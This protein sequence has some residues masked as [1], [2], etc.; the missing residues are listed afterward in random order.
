VNSYSV[1]FSVL[2]HLRNDDEVICMGIVYYRW[3]TMIA[4][5]VGVSFINKPSM[6][7]SSY[8]DIENWMKKIIAPD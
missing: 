1:E 4:L 3:A 2:N 6:F 8:E 5:S 7:S